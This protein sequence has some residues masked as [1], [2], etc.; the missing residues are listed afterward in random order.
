MVRAT[1]KFEVTIFS[2]PTDISYT[3]APSWIKLIPGYEHD[4]FSDFASL[5][6]LAF[7]EGRIENAIEPRESPQNHVKLPPDEHMLCYDY[8]YYVCAHQVGFLL[9]IRSELG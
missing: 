8:L 2:W 5:S 7:P 1:V 4:L 6:V 9:H 3:K